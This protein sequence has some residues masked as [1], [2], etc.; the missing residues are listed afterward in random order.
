MFKEA[1]A[2]QGRGGGRAAGVTPEQRLP[3]TLY[4]VANNI[5]RDLTWPQQPGNLLYYVNSRGGGITFRFGET[6][7]HRFIWGVSHPSYFWDLGLKFFIWPKYWEFRDLYQ[8]Q[9][10]QN[11]GSIGPLIDWWP[12]N[13]SKELS[14]VPPNLHCIFHPYS[15]KSESENK[16]QESSV[17]LLPIQ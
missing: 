2:K 10:W 16:G 13:A 1:S 9:L 11:D 14:W 6:H 7:R 5:C 12:S 8:F 4:L 15:E 17:E 3:A